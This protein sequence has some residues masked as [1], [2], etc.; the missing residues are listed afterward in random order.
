[1]EP[2]SFSFG[3]I[4]DSPDS[5]D[6]KFNLPALSSFPTIVDLRPL[7]QP[8]KN[9]GNLGSCT[10]FAT[11]AMVEYVRAK[12]HLIKWDA[13]PLFTYYSTRKIEN[14]I[15]EDSGAT[16]RDALKSVANDGVA[17]DTT[18]PY[19]IE[20]FTVQPPASAW[21]EAQEHQALV[22]YRLNQTKQDI[23]SCLADGYPFAFGMKIYQSFVNTQCRFLVNDV[24]P[25][26]V[27]SAEKFLG[28]HCMLAVGYLSGSEDNI[29]IKV[30]NSW[31]TYV[32]LDGYHNIPIQYFLDP[33]LSMDFWTIR[34]EETS[35]DVEP[36]PV[37]PPQPP[38]PVPSPVVPPTPDPVIPPTPTPPAPPTPTP[39]PV[40][41]PAPTPNTDNVSMWKQPITYVVIG[42]VILL[43]LFTTL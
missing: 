43:I 32:G 17:K 19:I 9:Q 25:M 24:L 41:P 40:T 39:E 42:F 2:I 13:S 21:A 38:V 8:I 33:S 35:N 28:G 4:P 23:I 6:Y 31:G 10:A 7:L 12:Q 5:R 15:N 3:Y 22:Y 16:V 20:N 14:C 1:M 11:T 18:W 37:T 34:Q 36:E 29:N 30:R 27:V 26:P